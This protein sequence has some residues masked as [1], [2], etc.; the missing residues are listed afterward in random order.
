MTSHPSRREHHCQRQEIMK[1]L[2]F[3]SRLSVTDL[4]VVITDGDQYSHRFHLPI[5]TP[6]SASG[7]NEKD[8]CSVLVCQALICCGGDI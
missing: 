3:G 1:Y 8:L 7:G 6:T 4:L 2:A 5:R